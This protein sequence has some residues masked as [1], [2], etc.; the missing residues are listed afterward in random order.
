MVMTAAEMGRKGAKSRWSKARAEERLEQGRRM[1]DSRAQEH[2]PTVPR[3]QD[4]RTNQLLVGDGKGLGPAVS[5][6]TDLWARANRRMK[7]DVPIA[8]YWQRKFQKYAITLEE[9]A[10]DFYDSGQP[11]KCSQVFMVLMKFT[12]DLAKPVAPPPPS[13]P[14]AEDATNRI[15]FTALSDEQLKAVAN[16]AGQDS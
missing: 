2:P 3:P 14:P 7:E 5:K 11:E 6:T 13:E 8:Q 15:D 1:A 16:R 12:R 4:V 9:I 10:K